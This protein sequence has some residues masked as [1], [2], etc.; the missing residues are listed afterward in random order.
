MKSFRRKPVAVIAGIAL[1]SILGLAQAAQTPAGAGRG[2][3]GRGQGQGGA[4]AAPG[5]GSASVRWEA[6]S[7][8]RTGA[9][10]VLGWQVGTAA[11]PR[12]ECTFFN[13]VEK[14]GLPGVAN[15][16]GS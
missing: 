3:P 6:W 10:T 2:L 11:E 5:R 13:E 16:D 7:A 14:A 4:T 12:H 1:G 9:S 8:M 15:I